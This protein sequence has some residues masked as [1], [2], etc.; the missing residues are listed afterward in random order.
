[1]NEGSMIEPRIIKILQSIVGGENVASEKQDLLCYS[2][3]ATQMQ[4]LPDVVVY[5]ANGGEV[6]LILKMANSEGI[7]V[8]P[9]GAGSGFSGGSLPK[10]GRIL[11]VTTRMNRIL[12]IET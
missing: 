1:M 9:R 11:L 2:Y 10:G 3:D 12:R 8:F 6:S 5:P 4:F 7:P